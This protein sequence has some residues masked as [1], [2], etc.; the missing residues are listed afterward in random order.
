MIGVGVG[1]GAGVGVGVG[2]GVGVGGITVTGAVVC[3]AVISWTDDVLMFCEICWLSAVI[4]CA[5][6]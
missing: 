6:G 1:V 5:V 4:A 2:A 3:I